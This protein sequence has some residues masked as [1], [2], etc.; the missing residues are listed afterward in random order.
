MQ[1]RGPGRWRCAG[2]SLTGDQTMLLAIRLAQTSCD[3]PIQAS[4]SA[5]DGGTAPRRVRVIAEAVT[6][7]STF[8]RAASRR[9][10]ASPRL[11][12]VVLDQRRDQRGPEAV[13]GRTFGSRTI[14]RRPASRSSRA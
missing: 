5:R 13:A 10:A 3:A 8:P 6:A 12:R 7:Y 14:A 1:E 4:I 9:V 2:S 11:E